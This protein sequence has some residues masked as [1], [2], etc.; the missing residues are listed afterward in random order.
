MKRALQAILAL[1]LSVCSLAMYGQTTPFTLVENFDDDSHFTQNQQVPNGWKS[2]GTLPFVRSKCTDFGYQAKSGEYVF[3]TKSSDQNG[4]DEVIYTP[5]V[6]LAKG[7]EANISFM[8]I[9]P[10]GDPGRIS[11][12]TIKAGKAQNMEAQTFEVVTINP[13]NYKEWYLMLGTFIPEEDGEYCFSIAVNAAE[14]Q[15]GDILLDDITIEGRHPFEDPVDELKPEPA[16]DTRA[17]DIPYSESFDNENNNYG[18]TWDMPDGWLS[19]GTKPFDTCYL[20]VLPPRTGTYYLFT[21]IRDGERD[22][23]VFTPF[24]K[25]KAGKTYV[26]RCYIHLDVNDYGS[27]HTNSLYAS[28]GTSHEFS[29]HKVF[30]R[31]DDYCNQEDW[32]LAEFKFTPKVDGSYCVGY[33][34]FSDG[35]YSGYAALEDFS[36]EEAKK[37]EAPTADFTVKNGLYCDN[38]GCLL[39]YNDKNV[40]LTDLSKGAAEYA[41]TA[42]AE[43]VKFS[44]PKIAEPQVTFAQSGEYTIYQTVKNESG[45]NTKERTFTVECSSEFKSDYGICPTSNVDTELNRNEIPTFDNTKTDFITGPNKYYK[46]FAQRIYFPYDLK[47][48]LENIDL[49]L[50]NLTYKTADQQN[51]KFDVVVYGATNGFLDE[52]KEYARYSSTMA[53]TFGTED[54]AQGKKVTINFGKKVSFEGD[55]FIAVIF[56]DAFDVTGDNASSV[57]LSAVNNYS[58]S[59]DIVVKAYNLPEGSEAELNRWTALDLVDPT[60]AGYGLNYVIWLNTGVDTGI[61][62]NESGDVVFA[63]RVLGDVVEVSGTQAGETVYLYNLNGSV[64]ASAVAQGESV[65]IP[66]AQLDKGVYIVKAMGG[67]QKVIK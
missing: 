14:G 51:C 40:Q 19:I 28:V 23:K 4:R 48:A 3:A 13:N 7:K 26:I 60:M 45:E 15:C 34:L 31:L 1:V 38:N 20:T 32:E 39:V 64:I 33:S 67:V 59:T 30:L 41:W 25:M 11:G 52:S 61:A 63:A 46:Q 43:S 47:V 55:C 24:F 35:G 54:P 65:S 66:A 58:K 44:D 29:Y 22:E 36:I 21:S 27:G 17:I 53:E 8:L 50:T 62:I 37:V 49:T 56:D 5:F 42:S 16:N 10:G 2:E 6:K 12:L 57:A 9:A 18:G